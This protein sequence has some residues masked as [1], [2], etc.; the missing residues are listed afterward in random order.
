MTEGSKL[1]DTC[2]GKPKLWPPVKDSEIAAKM[3]GN[4]E[5]ERFIPTKRVSKSPK[6]V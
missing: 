5:V 4:V 1:T 2:F 6:G 3:S